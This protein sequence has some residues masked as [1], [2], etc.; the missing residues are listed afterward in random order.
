MDECSSDALTTR[1]A[2]IV[3][4]NG[5]VFHSILNY[6]LLV[7]SLAGCAWVQRQQQQQ[8]RQRQPQPQPQLVHDK[9]HT[10]DNVVPEARS[11]RRKPPTTRAALASLSFTVVFQ[12]GLCW[13]LHC[14]GISIVWCAAAGWMLCGMGTALPLYACSGNWCFWVPLTLDGVGIIF[15]AVTSEFITT[16]AHACAVIMGATLYLLASLSYR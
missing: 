9:N 11:E 16:I 8:Q 14:S 3:S 10:N 4:Y 6:S 1:T 7:I 2:C 5:N 13:A 15:Y 12:V